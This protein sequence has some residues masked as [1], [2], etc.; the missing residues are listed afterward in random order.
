MSEEKL[1][2]IFMKT[3]YLDWAATTPVDPQV[4]MAMSPYFNE[5]FGN[6]SE[7]HFLGQQ[8]KIALEKFRGDDSFF[9]K[10]KA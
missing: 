1:P 5:V 2:D 8:A 6:P 9:F 3:T 10:S 7:P 4:I